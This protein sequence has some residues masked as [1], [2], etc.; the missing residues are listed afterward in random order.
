MASTTAKAAPR[1]KWRF[2][3][4]GRLLILFQVGTLRLSSHLGSGEFYIV[5]R[6]DAWVTT[7]GCPSSSPLSLAILSSGRRRSFHSIRTAAH[8]VNARMALCVALDPIGRSL[9]VVG[10]SATFS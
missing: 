9:S 8:L 4:R 6:A 3:K 7:M 1:A 5:S 10:S 2:A